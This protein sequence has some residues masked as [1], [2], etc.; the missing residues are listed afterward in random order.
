MKNL[1]LIFI[2]LLILCACSNNNVPSQEE[3]EPLVTAPFEGLDT[4]ATND[5]W[6]RATSNIIDVKVPREEV[7]AFGIYTVANNTL[8]LSAQL[9]PLYP[10]ETRGSSF[11]N[12]KG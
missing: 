10:N 3:M 4:S 8:K 2:S 1:F 12:K 11:R 7:I 9:F 6:N 5:W